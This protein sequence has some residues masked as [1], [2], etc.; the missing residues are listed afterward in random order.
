MSKTN[1]HFRSLDEKQHHVAKAIKKEVN[2]RSVKNI[3]RALKN[4]K[5][6][7]FFYEQQDEEEYEDER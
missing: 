3:D 4:R 5:Y 7:Q 1:K 6:D 2:D